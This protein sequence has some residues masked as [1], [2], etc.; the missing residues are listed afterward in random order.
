MLHDNRKWI[1]WGKNWKIARVIRSVTRVIWLKKT[2]MGPTVT[3]V[4]KWM[5]SILKQIRIETSKENTIS[6]S[7]PPNPT[8]S[9]NYSNFET[10]ITHSMDQNNHADLKTPLLE[11]EIAK[12]TNTSSQVTFPLR[13]NNFRTSRNS[14]STFAI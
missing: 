6:S 3:N 13:I 2:I 9:I 14:S 7:L 8:H 12:H 4:G 5:T 11:N 10:E 1:T